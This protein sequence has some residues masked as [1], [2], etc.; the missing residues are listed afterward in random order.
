MN[1]AYLSPQT[2]NSPSY[3]FFSSFFPFFCVD[4]EDSDY[5]GR[6]FNEV[7]DLKKM[8]ENTLG[9]ATYPYSRQFLYLDVK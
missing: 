9:V 1:L 6:D 8:I 4:E 5:V 3:F 7:M 2:L